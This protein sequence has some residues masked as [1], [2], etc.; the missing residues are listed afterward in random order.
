MPRLLAG[1][2][3]DQ[4]I[5]LVDTCTIIEAVRTGVWNRLTGAVRVETVEKCREEALA[6]DTASFG[7]IEVTPDDLR[8]ISTVHV[9]PQLEVD[10]YIAHDPDAVDMDEGEQMLFAHEFA[11]L[12]RGD[13]LWVLTSSDK[14][15]IRAAVRID[16][17]DALHSLE[18]LAGAVDAR[19]RAALDYQHETKFLQRFRAEYVLELRK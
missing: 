15:T 8:R 10:Q 16:I 2:P 13:Q 7:Y 11:R 14:A 5:V 19:P 9:V 4:T 17:H 3:L 6:G 1:V 12:Q 18:E